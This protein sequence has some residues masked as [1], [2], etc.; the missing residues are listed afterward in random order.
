MAPVQPLQEAL[1]SVAGPGVKVLYVSG[2]H[3]PDTHSLENLQ[4]VNTVTK[5]LVKPN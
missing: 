5:L 3:Q 4:T 2:T 1:L